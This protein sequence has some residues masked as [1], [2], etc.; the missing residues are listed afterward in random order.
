MFEPVTITSNVVATGWLAACGAGVTSCANAPKVGQR[1]ST[2]ANPIPRARWSSPAKT[3]ENLQ[4]LLHAGARI[5]RSRISSRRKRALLSLEDL[6]V[7]LVT[8]RRN[9]L[10]L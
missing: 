2:I 6:P 1:T 3:L 9:T 4:V 5:T 10:A 7:N 8:H